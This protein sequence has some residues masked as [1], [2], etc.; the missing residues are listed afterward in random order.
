MHIPIFGTENDNKRVIICREAYEVKADSTDFRNYLRS[1]M[2]NQD[3]TPYFADRN[4]WTRP[5][6]KWNSNESHEHASLF[7]YDTLVARENVDCMVRNVLGHCFKLKEEVIG[8]PN[9]M[10]L[11]L[12]LNLHALISLHTSE[13]KNHFQSIKYYNDTFNYCIIWFI[14]IILR[15]SYW[16]WNK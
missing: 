9:L 16:I 3:F 6:T 10:L 2:Y 1:L 14:H 13:N 4:A 15:N 7:T 11:L 8:P 12:L 5:I